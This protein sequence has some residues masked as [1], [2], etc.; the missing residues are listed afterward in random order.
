MDVKVVTYSTTVS[1]LPNQELM[2]LFC[3]T[4]GC[5]PWGS[6]EVSLVVWHPILPLTLDWHP[7]S[8]FLLCLCRARQTVEEENEWF[9]HLQKRLSRTV[10]PQ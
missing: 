3:S 5:L 9:I 2:F 4:L 1:Q 7:V 8:D 6:F 10:S